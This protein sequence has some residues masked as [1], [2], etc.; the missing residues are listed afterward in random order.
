MNEFTPS[1]LLTL[2]LDGSADERAIRRAYS[3]LVKHVDQQAD[4][5]K[6]M[7]LREAYEAALA[8]V[9]S[10]YSFTL[11]TMDKTEEQREAPVPVPGEGASECEVPARSSLMESEA[12][13]AETLPDDRL[14][15]QTL[16]DSLPNLLLRLPR[17]EVEPVK[18]VIDDLLH[19]EKLQ[20]LRL[21]R[22]FIQCLADALCAREFGMRS[23]VTLLAAAALLKWHES[24]GL[25]A[26]GASGAQL[27]AI[28][29]E[30]ST[31]TP[32]Q[33]QFY[34]RLTENPDMPLAL[35][36]SAFNDQFGTDTPLLTEFFYGVVHL[37]LWREYC[38]KP[39]VRCRM[40][41][42]G[43]GP[44][45]VVLGRTTWAL[46][47][48]PSVKV[49]CAV[50]L[51][52]GAMI[53][54]FATVL[55]HQTETEAAACQVQIAN[56][57][58]HRWK[59]LS[60]LEYRGLSSC[61]MRGH[62][63]TMCSDRMHLSEGRRSLIRVHPE[64][65]YPFLQSGSG[66]GNWVIDTSDGRAIAFAPGLMCEMKWDLLLNTA[67]FAV[68]DERAV[69]QVLAEM[70]GCP[71]PADGNN[72]LTRLLP[73]IEGWPESPEVASTVRI[74]LKSILGESV[75]TPAKVLPILPMN[76]SV[77]LKDF[78]AY[79]PKQMGS[80]AEWAAISQRSGK[81]TPAEHVFPS[82]ALLAIEPQAR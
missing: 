15:A 59:G 57:I 60:D 28:L 16:V 6:F 82:P 71:V 52:I 66:R 38:R 68:D 26:L 41:V 39:E 46:L 62:Q 79:D 49:Y 12:P 29:D 2:E 36:M 40:Y 10:G 45:L 51:V 61:Q 80:L 48:S 9:R 7:Q 14:E 27:E 17:D 78:D 3:R 33:L 73:Q 20:S 8:F 67:W 75:A 54:I 65:S 34:L 21:R 13:P 76:A 31:R 50:M 72:L 19:S 30:A 47:V 69:R 74:P 58:N 63:P 25:R 18:A 70:R 53:A 4:P 56:A 24:G 81:S 42:R 37:S 43:L 35:R 32:A 23:G 5:A 77:C 64:D 22:E 44:R 55:L 1:F 11:L